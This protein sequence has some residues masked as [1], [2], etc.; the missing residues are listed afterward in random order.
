MFVDPNTGNV[1]QERD[2]FVWPSFAN[3]LEVLAQNGGEDFY[4]GEVAAMLAADIGTGEGNMT[5]QDLQNY[6]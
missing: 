5:L 2:T 3:M 1:L 6:W 4:S